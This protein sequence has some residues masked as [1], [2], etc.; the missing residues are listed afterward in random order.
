VHLER[1]LPFYSQGAIRYPNLIHFAP[2][3]NTVKHRLPFR[4]NSIPEDLFGTYSQDVSGRCP[5]PFL[6]R[7]NGF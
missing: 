1:R 6:R 4:V 5:L 3:S 2:H 7:Q